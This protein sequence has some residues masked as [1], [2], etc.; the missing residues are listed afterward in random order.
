MLAGAD[1]TGKLVTVIGTR[2]VATK[3]GHDNTPLETRIL[4]P[5]EKFPNFERLNDACD[6]SEWREAFGKMVGPWSGQHCIYYIDENY[7]RYTWASPTTTIGSCICVHD[8]V[9]DFRIARKFRGP[10]V[11]PVVELSHVDFPTGY[12]LRQQPKHVVKRWVTLGLDRVG[13]LPD[14]GAPEIAASR[15][16]PA[17]AQPVAPLTVSEEVGDAIP[18]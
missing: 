7:R 3:W 15:G 9:E 12:G 11:F 2:N 18:F 14:H 16:A 1:V 13:A 6:R 8:I 17:D 4:A 5:G 10:A